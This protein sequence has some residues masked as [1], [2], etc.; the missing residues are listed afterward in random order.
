[1]PLTTETEL[2]VVVV[3]NVDDFLGFFGAEISAAGN[4]IVIV[5]MPDEG[6]PSIVEHPLDDAGGD[7]FVA[8][9]GFEHGALVV[10]GQAWA[11]RS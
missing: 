3:L 8:G 5:E 1:M 6:R 4:E 11:L 7:V 10:V 9:I 2:I